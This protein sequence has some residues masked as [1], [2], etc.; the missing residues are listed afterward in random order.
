MHLANDINSPVHF[1]EL[2]GHLWAFYLG[3]VS[4]IGHVRPIHLSISV[5]DRVHSYQFPVVLRRQPDPMLVTVWTNGDEAD[6]EALIRQEHRSLIQHWK[7]MLEN[8]H[9][10]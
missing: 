5:T 8:A 3:D 7:T 6:A 9:S 2:K 10:N 1:V 4:A